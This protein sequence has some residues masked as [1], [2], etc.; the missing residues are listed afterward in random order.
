MSPQYIIGHFRDNL[1]S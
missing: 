1:P